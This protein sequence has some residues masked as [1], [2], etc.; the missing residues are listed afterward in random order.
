M[1]SSRFDQTQNRT[2]C[3]RFYSHSVVSCDTPNIAMSESLTRKPQNE[4]R[5]NP[6]HYSVP[7]TVPQFAELMV[8]EVGR[9]SQSFE[10][11]RATHKVRFYCLLYRDDIDLTP[12]TVL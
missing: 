9:K 11:E 6:F 2:I 10:M 12:V 7:M 3:C 1:I 8:M 5:L 4:N